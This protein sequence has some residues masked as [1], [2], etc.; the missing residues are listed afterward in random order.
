[1]KRQA[2]E[3]V[4]SRYIE[5]IEKHSDRVP[6]NFDQSTIHDLRVGYKKIRAF[7][8][9]LQL[10]SHAGDLQMPVKL[11]AVYQTSGKVRDLQLFLVQISLATDAAS[12]PFYC[13]CCNRQLF[14]CKEQAV[15]AIEE[16]QFKKVIHSIKKELPGHL[17]PDTLRKFMQQKMAAINIVLLAADDEKDLHTIRKH[18]KDI[19]YV[20]RI[21][22]NDLETPFP[23]QEYANEKELSDMAARLGDFND[24][25][26][27]VSLLQTL[28]AGESMNNEKQLLQQLQQS[29]MRQKGEQ[30]KK[31][32]QEVQVLK[33]E[34]GL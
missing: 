34:H 25:C 20:I 14:A 15:Q 31:L 19:I 23:I 30:Q 21:Y 22:E 8:R 17:H 4:V 3:D 16:V 26:L 27:A 12:L 2:L 32:L 6:G 9:L 5:Q 28:C 7:L 10:E 13:K 11:K 33:A 18:L 1:M 24:C 29:W